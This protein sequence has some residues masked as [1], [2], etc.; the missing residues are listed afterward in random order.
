MLLY[1]LSNYYGDSIMN[2][3]DLRKMRVVSG[4]MTVDQ[5][6]RAYMVGVYALMGLGLLVTALAAYTISTLAITEHAT[7]GSQLLSVGGGKA[8][9]LS[10]FGQ[11]IFFSPLRYLLMFAPLIVV[12]ILGFRLNS[13]ST[14]AARGLFI[15]YAAL[16]GASLSSIFLIY[17]YSTIAECFLLSA[18][19]FGSLSLYGY[20]TQTDLRPMGAFLFMAVI[21]V[22]LAS[23]VNLFIHSANFSFGL[24]VVTVLIF[25]A[26]TAYDTQTIKE[27][28]Y[29]G[30]N[31][32]TQERKII[33]GALNLYIDFIN[34]FISL[35]QILG[36][37]RNRN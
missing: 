14:Q 27:F 25:A 21:G 28:Y 9:Y 37:D 34:I 18:A 13:L 24:S 12:F 19:S 26:L 20:V 2:F 36:F 33:L 1:V 15:L 23:L 7:A 35:L 30:D 11:A 4:D 6:L 3:S 16:V 5:G 8:V 32:D 17:S 22:I 29:A 31:S 10:S